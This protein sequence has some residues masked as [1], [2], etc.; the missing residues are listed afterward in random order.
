MAEIHGV[1]EQKTLDC[2]EWEERDVM[3]FHC[4]IR[5]WVVATIGR[6]DEEYVFG[7]DERKARTV[8]ENLTA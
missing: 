8:Y 3:L 5:G 2:G 1:V 4:S 7:Q 6:I